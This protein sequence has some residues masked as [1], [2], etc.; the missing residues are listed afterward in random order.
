MN[1]VHP[2][3]NLFIVLTSA[4]TIFQAFCLAQTPDQ[5]PAQVIPST[6]KTGENF[7]NSVGIELVWVPEG[8]FWIGRS[9]VT[10][11][12]FHTVMA[13]G[14]AGT[15]KPM[16]EVSVSQ[17]KAFCLKLNEPNAGA[18]EKPKPLDSSYQLPTVAQW[19][20][21]KAQSEPLGL[22][23][24]GDA[25]FEWTAS[26]HGDG[27]SR[28]FRQP[29]VF[30]KRIGKDYPVAM[31]SNGPLTLEPGTTKT[32]TIRAVSKTTVLWS[33]RLGFRVVLVPKP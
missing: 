22:L 28:I 6:V 18:G 27:L 33:G 21:A 25:L 12:Q 14:K 23:G 32:V 24:M 3:A 5:K 9:E 1:L 2:R 20:A 19:Q 17:A 4:C 30:P 16:E 13:D 8:R 26:I 10:E 11:K 31:D 15:E 29:P 7:T